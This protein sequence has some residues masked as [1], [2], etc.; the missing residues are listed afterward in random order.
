MSLLAYLPV[1]F[2]VVYLGIVLVCKILPCV[3][4]PGSSTFL[5]IGLTHAAGAADAG[6]KP[7]TS[8]SMRGTRYLPLTL[9]ITCV[10]V[11]V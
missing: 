5:P 4:R 2:G 9:R 3:G 7:R 1:S 8:T 6:A 10:W 11:T